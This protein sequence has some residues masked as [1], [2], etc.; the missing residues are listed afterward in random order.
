ME[1]AHAIQTTPKHASAAQGRQDKRRVNL[2]ARCAHETRYGSNICLE[3]ASGGM[4][5]QP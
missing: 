1:L 5:F 2:R 4:I 3:I